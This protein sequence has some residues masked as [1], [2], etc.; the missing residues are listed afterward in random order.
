MFFYI[1]TW[2]FLDHLL[3]SPLNRALSLTEV[4]GISKTITE[5]LYFDMMTVGLPQCQQ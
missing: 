2:T 5:N 3:M 1:W 4:Y